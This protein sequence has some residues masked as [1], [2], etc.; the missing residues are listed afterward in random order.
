MSKPYLKVN[1]FKAFNEENGM[2]Q[3]GIENIEY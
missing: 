1:H 3:S 2:I